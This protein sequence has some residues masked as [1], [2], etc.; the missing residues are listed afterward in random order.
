MSSKPSRSSFL[1]FLFP[2]NGT[3]VGRR[4]GGKKEM[5]LIDF[6]LRACA[7]R[8]AFSA[9]RLGGQRASMPRFGLEPWQLD[10]GSSP[11][12]P[13]S[14]VHGDGLCPVHPPF[15]RTLPRC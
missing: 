14:F 8:L 3:I 6:S 9:D 7:T 12:V 2:L 13:P 11:G 10:N 1:P 4:R 15:R 5:P